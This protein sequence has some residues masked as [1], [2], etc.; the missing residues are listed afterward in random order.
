MT[1]ISYD[2]NVKPSYEYLDLG[3]FG[4]HL[5]FVYAI[6]NDGMLAGYDTKS[7]AG[8]VSPDTPPGKIAGASPGYMARW[9]NLHFVPKT[10]ITDDF[11]SVA[12]SLNNHGVMAGVAVNQAAAHPL[13]QAVV[14]NHDQVINL[15]SLDNNRHQSRALDINETGQVAGTS[16]LNDDNTEQHAVLWDGD[17]ITDLGTLGGHNSAAKAI[18]N[19]G[20]VAGWS[21]DADSSAQHPALWKNG[22]IVALSPNQFGQASDIN[23]RGTVVGYTYTANSQSLATVWRNNHEIHLTN[24][25]GSASVASAVNNTDQVVG[26]QMARDYKQHAVL[27]NAFDTAP[28]DLNNYLD[29]A[30]REEGWVLADAKDINDKGWVV[31]TA[32]NSK[33]W[34]FHAY[35]LT[36]DGV[37]NLSVNDATNPVVATVVGTPLNPGPIH[38]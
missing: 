37:S 10:T 3:T 13:A 6:N 22:E 34:E 25:T 33:T 12:Y 19:F 17:T 30:Q 15:G 35:L 14:W 7:D 4:G 36:P 18:N 27:W 5:S 32:F 16:A 11:G 2:G 9:E 1:P 26:Y 21:Q 29:Q 28:V 24:G 31:G 20:A 23:D 38:I 8:N